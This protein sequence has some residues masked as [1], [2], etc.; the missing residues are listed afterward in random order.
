MN[1]EERIKVLLRSKDVE[2]IM[3]GATLLNTIGDVNEEVR[4]FRECC[5]GPVYT[6]SDDSSFL[7]DKKI[8][9]GRGLIPRAGP[10]VKTEN[11]TISVHFDTVFMM[12]GGKK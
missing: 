3:L 2:N 4:I 8:I 7:C 6:Y 1:L 5:D 12:K 11:W 9:L 10:D